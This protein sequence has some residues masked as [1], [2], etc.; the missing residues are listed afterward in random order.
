MDE[1]ALQGQMNPSLQ[2]KK[3]GSRK[4]NLITEQPLN[5]LYSKKYL[6]PRS[7][8]AAS[9]RVSLPFR[10]LDN[11]IREFAAGVSHTFIE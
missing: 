3:I 11:E 10:Q 5:I 4:R 9:G 8:F 7:K 1:F 2:S 6:F